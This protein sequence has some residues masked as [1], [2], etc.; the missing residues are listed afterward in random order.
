[1]NLK[2][3]LG[4]LLVILILIVPVFGHLSELPIQ[5]WDESRLAVN[6]FEMYK[7]HNWLVTHFMWEPDMWNTKPPLL[8]WLQVASLNVF[9]VNELAIRIPSALAAVVTCLFMYGFLLKKFN[10]M[11]LAIAAPAILI[12]AEGY[13]RLHGIRTGDYDALLTMF[14]TIFMLNF[15]VYLK[16]V[17]PGRLLITIIVL[18]LACLTKGIPA[19]MFGPAMLAM[20]VYHK[21][22]KQIF[23]SW[24]FY[25]GLIIF[26][27]LVP[28]Y[29]L[30]R[31]HYNPGYLSAVFKNELGGR[32]FTALEDHRES[33]EFYFTK[34][35]FL[36][37][38]CLLLA[39]LGMNMAFYAKDKNIRDL[40]AYL[41]IAVISFLVIISFAETKLDWYTIPV[42]PLMS[43]LAA[44]AINTMV[45]YALKQTKVKK[46]VRIALL[47]VSIL[48]LYG[49]AYGNIMERALKPMIPKHFREHGIITVIKEGIE[50]KR[51]MSN[52]GIVYSEYQQD[53]IWYEHVCDGIKRMNFHEFEKG[54][55]ALV[56]DEVS[57]DV[58]KD[59]FEC[60][61]VHEHHGVKLLRI[62]G[63]KQ[64]TETEA[65]TLR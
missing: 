37:A 15:Y 36:D 42:Y 25:T 33:W 41:A 30:L 20:A 62:H 52:V 55:Q 14:T 27:L 53:I 38:T 64:N 61:L 12:V 7:N 9:G 32:F 35:Y 13:T 51:D 48:C 45:D 17:K 11:L 3:L 5:T 18:A 54:D 26:I 16:E 6:A 4:A 50:G 21:K 39:G 24:E 63:W 1:M 2:N 29:Y 22:L 58:I 43:I 28:G 56:R 8:I 44:I 57:A 34:I 59:M 47:T 10:N 31:E 65:D 46:Q 49:I 19:L 60:D 40:S 23:T